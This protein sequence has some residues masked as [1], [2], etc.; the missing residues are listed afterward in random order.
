MQLFMMKSFSIECREGAIHAAYLL[1]ERL[2][3][4]FSPALERHT[5][6]S[7]C[8]RSGID[9]ERIRN[10]V[11]PHGIEASGAAPAGWASDLAPVLAMN[12]SS[13]TTR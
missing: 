10:A 11:A 12:G 4:G 6:A 2:P 7:T 8:K 13:F 9:Q 3:D 1:I 5:C